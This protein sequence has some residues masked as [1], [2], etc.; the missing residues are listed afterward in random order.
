[1]RR[2]E[3]VIKEVRRAFTECVGVQAEDV[4]FV[5]SVMAKDWVVLEHEARAKIAELRARMVFTNGNQPRPLKRLGGGIRCVTGADG[6]GLDR[7]TA[8]RTLI[9][10]HRVWP[11]PPHVH[12]RRERRARARRPQPVLIAV[13][14]ATF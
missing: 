7:L 10:S 13:D 3:R 6:E 14:N 12:Q 5:R 1:M 9:P 2:R 11:Q 4:K 8:S